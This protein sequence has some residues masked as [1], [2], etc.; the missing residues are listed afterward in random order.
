[1]W[2]R[3]RIEIGS[4]EVIGDAGGVVSHDPNR[5]PYFDPGATAKQCTKSIAKGLKIPQ[6]CEKAK[7]LDAKSGQHSVGQD[8]EREDGMAGEVQH[9]SG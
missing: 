3:K 8:N 7:F 1:L 5:P 4:D 6:D 9:C 2:W